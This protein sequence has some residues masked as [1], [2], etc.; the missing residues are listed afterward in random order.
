M[1]ESYVFVNGLPPQTREEIQE[2]IIKLGH[3]VAKIESDLIKR[4]RKRQA[5]YNILNRFPDKKFFSPVEIDEEAK[6]LEENRA[7]FE[8]DYE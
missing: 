2:G 6:A 5:M 1:S 8:H 3:T 7:D 4:E